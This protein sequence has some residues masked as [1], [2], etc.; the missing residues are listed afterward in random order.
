MRVRVGGSAVVG[1]ASVAAGWACLDAYAW[2]VWCWWALMRCTAE[3]G[4][5]VRGAWGVEVK[6]RAGVWFGDVLVHSRCVWPHWEER[7]ANTTHY[8]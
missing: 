3:L 1:P 7:A 8:S 2:S 6:W 5:G 4:V